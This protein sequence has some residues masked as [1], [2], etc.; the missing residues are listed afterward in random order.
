M[1]MLDTL[2]FRIFTDYP[3][4]TPEKVEKL[5]HDLITYTRSNLMQ[6]DISN[7][8]V[9]TVGCH[10]ETGRDHIHLNIQYLSPLW[11]DH[12]KGS[13][14]HR[15]AWFVANQL[16]HP[17]GQDLTMTTGLAKTEDEANNHLSYP[18]KEGIVVPHAGNCEHG[19]RL[20]FL[21]A[22]GKGLYEAEKKAKA[23][24]LKRES[25][26]KN[27]VSQLLELAKA[28][29]ENHQ[30]YEH[31]EIRRVVLNRFY[32]QYDTP[33]EQPNQ[34]DVKNAWQ[35]VSIFLRIVPVDYYM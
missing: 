5:V 12:K 30:V 23:D 8:P 33:L 22:R 35:K 27:I 26:A 25:R 18:F 6:I 28:E 19:P 24:K 21:I 9:L 4:N 15:K 14:A 20:E 34:N 11:K 31:H 16:E 32:A 17:T 3:G 10:R 29:G 1:P 2:S 13:S 7:S